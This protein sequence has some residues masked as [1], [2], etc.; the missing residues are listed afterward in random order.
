MVLRYCLA[1]VPAGA[2]Y[3]TMPLIK[4]RS[5]STTYQHLRVPVQNFTGRDFQV[6][7]MAAW[8]GAN[9]CAA[10][11]LCAFH[12]ALPPSQWLLQSCITVCC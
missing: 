8:Q 1:C 3:V 4:S 7:P 12:I 9:V 10:A 11:L 2:L 6:R 5:K